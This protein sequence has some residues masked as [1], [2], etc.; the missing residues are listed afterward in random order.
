MGFFGKLWKTIKAVAVFAIEASPIGRA[1]MSAIDKIIDAWNAPSRGGDNPHVEGVVNQWTQTYFIPFYKMVMNRLMKSNVLSKNYIKNFNDTIEV[2]YAWKAYFEFV[3]I[4]E[5]DEDEI[6]IAQ[7]KALVIS[8]FID[9][10]RES[11]LKAAGATNTS[12]YPYPFNPT[13]ITKVGTEMLDWRGVKSI[14]AEKFILTDKPHG[15]LPPNG[16][17]GTTT[18]S[19]GGNTTGGNTIG[20]G[21]TTTGGGTNPNTGGGTTYPQ[22]YY[23]LNAVEKAIYQKY[24][25]DKN[26]K[27]FNSYR[28]QNP[29]YKPTTALLKLLGLPTTGI[30]YIPGH[31]STTT[32]GSNTGGGNTGGGNTTGGNSTGGTLDVVK[33]KSGVNPNT[34]KPKSNLLKIGVLTIAL[35]GLYKFSKK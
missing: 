30:P 32:G 10:L 12:F 5:T 11:W 13:T 34:A 15:G 21:G 6:L 8:E 9:V 19:G 33:V 4:K 22:A 3:A 31:G 17:G 2:L 24:F 20:G 14:T 27:Y 1:A 26:L 29:I 35:L 16:G 7:H 28:Q 18:T 23:K 25:K